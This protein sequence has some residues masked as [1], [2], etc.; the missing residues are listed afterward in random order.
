[1]KLRN[2]NR[3]NVKPISANT[4]TKKLT[5]NGK[6]K[7]VEKNTNGAAEKTNAIRNDESPRRGT[8]QR[9]AKGIH[10]MKYFKPQR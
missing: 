9:G 7:A 3:R 8:E 6:A 10:F 4:Q 1:M 5:R 2:L